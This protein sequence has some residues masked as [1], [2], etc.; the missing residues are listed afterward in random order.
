MTVTDE[1]ET[2]VPGSASRRRLFLVGLIGAVLAVAITISVGLFVAVSRMPGDDSAE[3]GFARDMSTH[4]GQAVEMAILAVQ[5]S[6]LPEIGTLALDIAL[7]QQ[8]QIGMMRAWLRQWNLSPTATGPRMAWMQDESGTDHGGMATP[9][10]PPARAGL[11]PG[12]ATDDELTALREASGPAFDASFTELMIRHHIGGLE[13]VDAVLA[14][15]PVEQVLELAE[16][17]KRGQQYEIEALRQI[18]TRLRTPR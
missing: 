18:Q 12:M 16:S 10:S 8:A 6:E 11:M 13:M 15:D 5:R 14:R 3:A 2:V 9:S 17:M 7:T 4:H 1:P